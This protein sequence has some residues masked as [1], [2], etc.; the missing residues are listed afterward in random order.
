MISDC[1]EGKID[2]IITKSS[3]RFA[4]NTVDCLNYVRK[5]RLIGVEIFFEKDNILRWNSNRCRQSKDV[6]SG[7]KGSGQRCKACGVYI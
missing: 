7:G 2:L 1:N 5:L 3:S 6:K 4:R